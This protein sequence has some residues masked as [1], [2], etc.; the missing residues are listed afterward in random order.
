LKRIIFYVMAILLVVTIAV[1]PQF[2]NATP[3]ETNEVQYQVTGQAQLFEGTYN[4]RVKAG[5]QELINGYGTASRGGPEWGDFKQIIKVSKKTNKALT[6][7]LYEKDQANGQEV[8]KLIIPLDDTKG[9]VFQNKIFKNV[10]V[11]KL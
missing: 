7:E 11:S 3:L 9:K 10:K 4:Y 8:N 2:V 1:G 6:L 5:N